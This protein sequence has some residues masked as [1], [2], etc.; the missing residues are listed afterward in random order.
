M[1]PD[2]KGFFIS[3]VVFGALVGALL[4]YALPWAWSLAKPLIHALTA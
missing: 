1:L 3:L 2:L 4:A